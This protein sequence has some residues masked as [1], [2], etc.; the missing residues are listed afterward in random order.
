MCELNSQN[1]KLYWNARS[2][3]PEVFCTPQCRSSTV[4]DKSD[5]QRL[6]GVVNASRDT[7]KERMCKVVVFCMFKISSDTAEGERKERF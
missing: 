6:I 4:N 7:K 3:K 1:Q 5:S 2:K